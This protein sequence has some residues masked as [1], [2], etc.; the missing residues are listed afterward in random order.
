[1]RTETATTYCFTERCFPLPCPHS[2]RQP[3][4][5][6]AGGARTTAAWGTAKAMST[7][8]LQSKARNRKGNSPSNRAAQSTTSESPSPSSCC[9]ATLSPNTQKQW[10]WWFRAAVLLDS[11][12]SWTFSFF[13]ADKEEDSTHLYFF[14]CLFIR[15]SKFYLSLYINLTNVGKKKKKRKNK[16]QRLS[17]RINRQKA[18]FDKK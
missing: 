4:L 17:N 5:T 14:Y 2:V 12:V 7:C 16:P 9:I 13:S 11:P 6:H 15:A 10:E 18:P 1:M 3:C 8:I